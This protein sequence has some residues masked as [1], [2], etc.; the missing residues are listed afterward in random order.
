MILQQDSDVSHTADD[1]PF[2]TEATLRVTADTIPR[3]RQWTPSL[4]ARQGIVAVA[5]GLI[6][7]A[8]IAA[9]VGRSGPGADPVVSLG[10]QQQP[11]AAVI[12]TEESEPS[13]TEPPPVATSSTSEAP[14]VTETTGEASLPPATTSTT[15]PA[16]ESTT[17]TSTT[18]PPNPPQAR[19][20]VAE[21]E[22]DED[23]KID[24][25]GNDD[26]GDAPLD[27]DTLE[28][29]GP[30][31]HAEK[32]GVRDDHVHYKS[33]EGFEGVDTLTYRICDTAGQCSTAVLS[34][35]VD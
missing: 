32:Y 5:C 1:P 16:T 26:P 15:E 20:D 12:V 2:L 9:Y 7:L 24:V 19:D 6:G 30:P 17:T 10:D 23:E 3:G 28:I 33:D 18:P 27:E 34:V 21:A 4:S 29:V 35:I 22:E 8:I 31:E 14:T 11:A 25:L 13:S